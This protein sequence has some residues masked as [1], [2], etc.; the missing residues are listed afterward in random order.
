MS[1]LNILPADMYI[2]INKNILTESKRQLLI[3]LYQ[4]I[5]GSDAINLYQTLWSY[6]DKEEVASCEWSHHHLMTAMKTKLSTIVEAK[7]KLEAVGLIKTYVKKGSVNS[8]VYEL[9]SPLSAYEF[10]FNPILNISLL[11]NVGKT[12]YNR[13]LNHFKLPK[14]N[15]HEYEDISLK[16]TDVFE[17]VDY[18]D[19]NKSIDDIKKNN[20]LG[21]EIAN[22]LD[23]TN[24]ISMLPDDA[25]NQKSLTGET[26]DFIY[27][28]GFIYALDDANMAEIIRNSLDAK[29]AID[30][31]LMRV[32]T[33]NYY[34]FEN[35]GQLPTIVYK[36]QPEYLRSDLKEVNKR[37]KLIYQFETISPYEFL[38]IKN[39]NVKPSKAELM[40]LETLLIDFNLMPG[41]VNVLIDFV[42]RI[43]D[44]KLPRTYV[45]AIASQWKKSNIMT[46]IDA[47]NYAEANY[48]KKKT[49]TKIKLNAKP[50]W[51]DKEQSANEASLEEETRMNE[52]LKSFK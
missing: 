9:Y 45:E 41:V 6:L 20:K 46:V 40:L 33:R 10:F 51:M 23:I 34:K 11:N 49:T 8:Y 17:S 47:M 39:G 37:T 13:L 4:P 16:F 32:N 38:N 3:M 50:E 31:E 22:K 52:L 42:L 30:K 28:L 7:E 48:K 44:N 5:I 12:E 1:K 21:L 15:L 2:V 19:Y 27:K 14:F 29:K 18:T 25:I 26:K 43:N 24:I 35:N 36:N